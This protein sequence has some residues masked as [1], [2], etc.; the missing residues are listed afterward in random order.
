MHRWIH[1]YYRLKPANFAVMD[2]LQALQNGP[3][4]GWT[5]GNI[6]TDRM[7]MRLILASRD[8]IALDTVES[9]IVG[10]DP[11]TIPYLG[12]LDASKMGTA[13]PGKIRVLGKRVDE[14][15]KAFSGGSSC[16]V[17]TCARISDA[18]APKLSIGPHS[19]SAG[20]LS[21]SLQSDADLYKVEVYA[22][23]ALLEPTIRQN[24]ANIQLDVKALP[25]Q[26][27][28][29]KVIGYDYYLNATQITVAG[30]AL[31]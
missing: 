12:L 31:P 4:S 6:D 22:G 19:V 18:A 14:V 27:Y 3:Y 9:L 28:D 2:A 30:V 23:S 10:W 26:T 25:A 13:D 8:A 15:R 17:K 1:D 11:K 20:M 5:G 16:A 7:N 21:L 29:L 24:F